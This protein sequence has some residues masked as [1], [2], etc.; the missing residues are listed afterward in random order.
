MVDT[1][2]C[3]TQ[4][5]SWHLVEAYES[6]AAQLP[7][8]LIQHI[9]STPG[10]DHHA[11]A[12]TQSHHTPHLLLIHCHWIALLLLPAATPS[13]LES[14]NN[15]TQLILQA[16]WKFSI[17]KLRWWTWKL[18][19]PTNTKNRDTLGH[20]PLHVLPFI[21]GMLMDNLKKKDCST[22]K[23]FVT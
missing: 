4:L 13:T 14:M 6:Y 5:W 23:K 17:L 21:T 1:H 16:G 2:I 7:Q 12:L 19:S 18:K 9:H 15:A 8:V 11:P 10:P 3:K 22:I 20:L